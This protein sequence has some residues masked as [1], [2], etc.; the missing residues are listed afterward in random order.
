MFNR[1]QFLVALIPL[2]LAACGGS[3]DGSAGSTS[4]QTDQP[5]SSARTM[6]E[7]FTQNVQ[8]SLD[9]CRT[10]HVAG[11]LADTDKGR[12]FMLS[13]SKAQDLANL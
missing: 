10:C 9:F 2:L 13:T 1:S 12:D 7:H 11:G 6:D 8:P 3:Y 4:G 5:G